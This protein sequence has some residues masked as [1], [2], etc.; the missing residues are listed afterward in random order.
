MK[1]MMANHAPV[2]GNTNDRAGGRHDG[3]LATGV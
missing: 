2:G 3:L 1:G